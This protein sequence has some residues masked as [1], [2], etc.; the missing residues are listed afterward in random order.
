M[1]VKKSE[2]MIFVLFLV[3]RPQHAWSKL[4]LPVIAATEVKLNLPNGVGQLLGSILNVKNS[5]AQRQGELYKRQFGPFALNIGIDSPPA[6]TYQYTPENYQ[7]VPPPQPAPGWQQHHLP[8]QM[9][10]Y[11]PYS[12]PNNQY[13]PSQGSYYGMPSYYPPAPVQPS[14]N[15]PQQPA[16]ENPY[17][18]PMYPSGPMMPLVPITELPLLPNRPILPKTPDVIPKH[19]RKLRKGTI[20]TPDSSLYVH[21]PEEKPSMDIDPR[22]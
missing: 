6:Q 22:R 3:L 15:M 10:G 19:K 16:M 2:L 5:G 18:R 14:H 17:M 12:Q 13:L 20:I 8:Y 1:R 11:Y 4:H 7:Y 21:I 9:G